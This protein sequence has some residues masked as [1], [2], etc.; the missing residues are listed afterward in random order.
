MRSEQPE[1]LILAHIY[2]YRH[3]ADLGRSALENAG[4]E[5]LIDADDCGGQEPPLG[6]NVGVKLLVHRRDE[7]KAKKLLE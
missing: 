6:A 3:E 5:A 7:G 1:D 4:I 2:S